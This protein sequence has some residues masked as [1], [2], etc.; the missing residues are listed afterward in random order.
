M[1]DREYIDLNTVYPK[2]DIETETYKIDRI[3]LTE[4][5]VINEQIRSRLDNKSWLTDGLKSNFEYVRLIKKGEGIMMSDTPMER[6]TN[7]NFIK[8][9]NGDVLIFGLGL[10]MVIIPLLSAPEVKSITVVELYQD[11]IDVIYPILKNKD[12]D[13]KLTIVQGNCFEYHN[14]IP[15]EKK[16]DCVYGDIWISISV[17]NYKEMKLL[18]QNWKYRINRNNPNSF[19]DHWCKKYLL[20]EIRKEKKESYFENLFLENAPIFFGDYQL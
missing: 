8:K 16:F 7:E 6:N 15:K 3:V 20:N 11:L 17:D 1:K 14:T 18:T 12:K 13:N 5:Q 2:N 9:A 10:G 19:I 4:N